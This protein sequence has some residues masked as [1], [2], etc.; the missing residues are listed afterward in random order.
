MTNEV[1][2]VLKEVANQTKKFGGLRNLGGYNYEFGDLFNSIGF[3]SIEI[4]NFI[5]RDD[6]SPEK[7][8]ED[9]IQ[10]KIRNKY[11]Y[12]SGLGEQKIKPRVLRG[13]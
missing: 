13:R 5:N 1:G 4:M 12:L 7:L 9:F 10:E 2:N 6:L 8:A 11:V 3:N